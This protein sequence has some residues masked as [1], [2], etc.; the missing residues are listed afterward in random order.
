M[1]RGVF[2]RP[3]DGLI[4]GI[5]ASLGFSA[6]ENAV[7]AYTGGIGVVLVKSATTMPLHVALGAI[8]GGLIALA[9]GSPKQ[10]RMIF[11]LG[12]FLPILLHG[13]YNYFVLT[14]VGARDSSNGTLDTLLVISM[15]VILG[16]ALFV[17][18]RLR[19]LDAA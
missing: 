5:V 6:F 3:M 2:S 15:A 1:K 13:L 17:Y 19:K 8:M 18:G 7:Y 14:A 11:G 9:G 10:H 4:Y 16:L 12:L